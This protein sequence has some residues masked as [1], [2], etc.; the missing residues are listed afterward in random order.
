MG[1]HVVNPPT[2]DYTVGYTAL[3]SCSDYMHYYG[4]ASQVVCQSAGL[5]PGSPGMLPHTLYQGGEG[6]TSKIGTNRR[7]L[8]LVDENFFVLQLDLL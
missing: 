5:G 1:V 6:S 4:G 3:L 8:N 2:E 7:A